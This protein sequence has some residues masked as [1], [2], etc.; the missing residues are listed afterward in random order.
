MR[1]K[2]VSVRSRK[3]SK[4]NGMA[5]IGEIRVATEIGHK[6]RARYI[7]LACVD[8]GKE[9]WVCYQKGKTE[10][11][12]CPSCSQKFWVGE[13]SPAWKG[14]R[15]T[16]YGYILKR[17]RSEEFF[18]PMAD[19]RG[20][21]LEHR[22]AMAKKLGRCLQSWEIVHHKNG[23]RDDNCVENLELVTLGSHT[24]AHSKGYRDGYLKGLYDSHEARIKQLEARVTLLEAE[25]VSLRS[26]VGITKE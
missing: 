4:G 6:G 7:W 11:S 10:N 18:S 24:I 23:I 17:V 20:Y 15:K 8:C 2:F 19:K 14:G 22:L 1:G 26:N 9:R 21:V 16:I 3:A 13:R 5:A 12:R 25:N